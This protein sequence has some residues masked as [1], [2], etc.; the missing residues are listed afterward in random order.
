[1]KIVL[2]NNEN[3]FKG[4]IIGYLNVFLCTEMNQAI[5]IH[6]IIGHDGL[7]THNISAF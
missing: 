3:L 1:M 7:N 2:G 4:I 6:E 5:V